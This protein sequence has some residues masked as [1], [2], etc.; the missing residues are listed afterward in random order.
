MRLRRRDLNVRQTDAIVRQHIRARAGGETVARLPIIDARDQIVLPRREIARKGQRQRI[1]ELI[2][3]TPDARR[4][5]RRGIRPDQHV[6]LRQRLLVVVGG[7]V[8]EDRII[9]RGALERAPDGIQVDGRARR[10]VPRFTGEGIAVRVGGH[11]REPKRVAE[12]C[13]RRTGGVDGRRRQRI[14]E[15]RRCR[16]A[17]ARDRVAAG[18]GQPLTLEIAEQPGHERVAPVGEVVRQLQPQMHRDDLVRPP[19]PRAVHTAVG[20]FLCV[21]DGIFRV[22]PQLGEHVVIFRHRLDR[23]EVERQ[24]EDRPRRDVLLVGA[25]AQQPDRVVEGRVHRMLDHGLRSREEVGTVYR[26]EAHDLGVAAVDQRRD[27]AA[28]ERVVQRLHLSR[29]SDKKPPM[30]RLS[31]PSSAL[32]DFS[33]QLVF[34]YAFTSDNGKRRVA[35][36]VFQPATQHDHHAANQPAR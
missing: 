16:D 20:E 35:A 14:A 30:H 17:I 8:Q 23:L 3:R 24:V 22:R 19:Y 29:Q 2:A 32:I 7:Q 12:G 33:V 11:Q 34:E 5:I 1:G 6:R 26:D 21:G 18:D 13:G 25:V 31:S 28:A 9:L 15:I 27:A 4:V 10:H 36:L